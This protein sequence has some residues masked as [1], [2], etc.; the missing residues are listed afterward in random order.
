MCADEDFEALQERKKLFQSNFL[1][2]NSMRSY[3]TGVNEFVTFTALFR[4]H[5]NVY[6]YF[7]ISDDTLATFVVWESQFI[8][9]A[10][11]KSYLAGVRAW[12]MWNGHAFPA[13]KER[14][15]VFQAF[16][17][18]KRYF[19]A[20]SV[21]K[22][23][24][25]PSMLLRIY[26]LL[27]FNDPNQHAI[28]AAMLLAYYATLRKD[29]ISVGKA[30]SFNPRANL[31]LSDLELN[32]TEMTGLLHIKHAKQNQ[33]FDR[34]HSIPIHGYGGK[35]CVITALLSMLKATSA[36]NRTGDSALFQI[37]GAK[38]KWAPMT[39]S[40]FTTTFKKLATAARYDASKFAGHSFR[41]G[42]ATRLFRLGVSPELIKWQGDWSSDAWERYIEVDPQAK[43]SVPLALIR[44]AQQA[45]I[46]FTD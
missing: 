26:G 34:S 1:S 33:F 4:N 21:S 17:G 6:P 15:P 35:L 44:D 2:F 22:L 11:I 32:P 31:T 46:S 8:A 5:L 39:H 16:Q 13:M 24:V 37:R 28:W 43:A 29:N 19:G 23:E 20:P 36:A 18:L 3:T 30:S 14:L 25:T 38:G 45:E 40:H 9:P 10:S 27:D 12:Q 41:R 7:P 42:S